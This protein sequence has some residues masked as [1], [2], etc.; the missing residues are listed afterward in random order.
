MSVE[1]FYDGDADLA[2]IAGRKVAVIGYGSQGHA[3]ALSLRDSG[4][5]VRVG[6]PDESK[7]RPKA[8]DEGLAVMTPAQA[9]AEAD[10]IMILAPDT[11]Q[12][13]IYA[14]DIA[15]NLKS[16]DALLFGH[17]FNIRYD[18]IRPPSDVD[19]AMVA[20]KGPGHLVRRQFVDGKGVPCLIAVEQDPTGGAQALALSYAKAIGGTRAGVIKTT[21]TEETETDLFG[22][23]TVLCGGI[24]AL[25]QAGFEVLTE[26]GYAPEVAYFECLHEVKL[27][28]DLMYEGGI[29]R[30]RYSISDTAEYGDLT[31]GPRIITPEVKDEMRRILSEIQDGR[32]AQEWVTEDDNGRPNFTKLRAEGEQHP[33]EQVGSRL[34]GLMSWIDRPLT[35][36]A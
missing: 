35:D 25:V 3:H 16:G 31:R 2:I 33:I 13:A 30:M 17:G 28:V 8:A 20:P 1:V 7:S 21:F 22:E 36:T 34:R 24:T 14:A 27:I 26:A 6:L 12:R 32:F 11:K 4:V 18:L 15:P 5:D 19:V 10:V 9:S 29:S 23:Q